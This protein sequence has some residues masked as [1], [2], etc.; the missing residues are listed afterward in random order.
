MLDKRVNIY[1]NTPITSVNPPIRCVTLN[2]TKNIGVIRNCIL[3]GAK[4]EEVLPTGEIIELNINNYDKDNSITI[5]KIDNIKI[6]DIVEDITIE[7][8]EINSNQ[9]QTQS[10]STTQNTYKCNKKNKHK[11]RYNNKNETKDIEYV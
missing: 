11:S 4:V 6:V 2:S 9:E 5:E 10:V 3:A 1:P 7:P 8:K